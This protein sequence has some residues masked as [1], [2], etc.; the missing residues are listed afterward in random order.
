MNISKSNRESTLAVSNDGEDFIYGA[1]DDD[2]DE[3]NSPGRDNKAPKN[4]TDYGF[5]DECVDNEDEEI[6]ATKYIKNLEGK[7]DV[8][9]DK[10]NYSPSCEYD[11]AIVILIILFHKSR[12]AQCTILANFA[13]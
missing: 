4:V 10:S 7:Q 6:V 2:L 12:G 11:V 1:V 5:Y 13:Q 3:Q 8:Q 9:I